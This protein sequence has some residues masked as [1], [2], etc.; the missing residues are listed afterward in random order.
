M[1]LLKTAQA[2]IQ[3][4]LEQ[5]FAKSEAVA[6]RELQDRLTKAKAEIKRKIEEAAAKAA[7]ESAMWQMGGEIIGGVLGGALTIATGGA[8]APFVPLMMK[9]G[10]A[11][12]AGVKPTSETYKPSQQDIRGMIRRK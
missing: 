2:K 12:G 1:T 8:A 10:G 5:E 6:N 4:S 9:A 11:I 7:E 3:Q